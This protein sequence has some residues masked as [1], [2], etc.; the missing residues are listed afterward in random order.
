MGLR[1]GG[2]GRRHGVVVGLAGIVG[3]FAGVVGLVV[4]IG[5]GVGDGGGRGVRLPASGAGLERR[6]DGVDLA[7][8]RGELRGR[9]EAGAYGRAESGRADVLVVV[10]GEGRGG[11]V[12]EKLARFYSELRAS[13]A[14]VVDAEIE[15]VP[16]GAAGGVLRC[17]PVTYPE[18]RLTLEMCVWADERS[19]GS[20]VALP[21]ADNVDTRDELVQVTRDMHAAVQGG[22][23]PP[24]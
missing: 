12:E 10:A 2:G 7:A 23:N 22:H 20:V 15:A 5:W 6:D 24:T 16:P 14:V 21:G 3:A 17:Q 9:A 4:L 1:S 8:V 11:A 18:Q 13:G 19:V